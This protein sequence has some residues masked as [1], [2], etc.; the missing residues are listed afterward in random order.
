MKRIKGMSHSLLAI[1]RSASFYSFISQIFFYILLALCL[2][3]NVVCWLVLLLLLLFYLYYLLLMNEFEL[4]QNPKSSESIQLFALLTLGE[5]GRHMY[6]NFFFI[7]FFLFSFFFFSSF[8]VCSLSEPKC[9]AYHNF[10][11][12]WKKKKLLVGGM[13]WLT[14]EQFKLTSFFFQGSKQPWRN[15]ERHH[16]V[17]CLA[18]RRSQNSSVL[19]FRLVTSICTC[20]ALLWFHFCLFASLF[21]FLQVL[22]FANQCLHYQ[23]CLPYG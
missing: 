7:L 16:G 10:W 5:I 17:V 21:V 1:S 9:Y 12:N 18:Q 22:V 23:T 13:V 4:L 8:F 6:V 19:C 15:S 14:W 11:C 3:L 20:T 2:L